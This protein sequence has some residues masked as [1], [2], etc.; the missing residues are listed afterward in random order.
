MTPQMREEKRIDFAVIIVSV[1]E[2]L[3]NS[4]AGN[5][6]ANPWIRS[7]TSPASNDGEAQSAESRKD[8]IHQM[9]ISLKELRETMVWLKII[10]RKRLGDCSEIPAAISE[11]HELIAIFVSRTKTADA[12]GR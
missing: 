5:P 1:V 2:A 7:G 12:N 4:K 10:A 3:P 11:C 9:K 8:F 6:I